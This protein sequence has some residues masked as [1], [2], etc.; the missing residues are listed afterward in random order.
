MNFLDRFRSKP[1]EPPAVQ[2]SV[3]LTKGDEAAT[4]ADKIPAALAGPATAA[5]YSLMKRGLF[6]MR[7]NVVVLLDHSGSMRQ[8]FQDGSITQLTSRVLAFALQIDTDGTVPVICFDSRIWPSVDVTPANF[9]T[10][11][12]STLWRPAQMGTTDL[13]GALEKILPM[14]KAA[15]EPII[16]VIITDGNPNNRDAATRLVC[17]LA[18]YPVWIK[19]L[20]LE[21]VEYLQALDDLGPDV[22]IVD[23]VDAQTSTP[24]RNLL[25]CSDEVFAEAMVEE[26]E[27]WVAAA[28]AKGILS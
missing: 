9:A 22:R 4:P 28:T 19:I 8:D 14:A 10:I 13:A 7:G 27:T 3:K 20:A 21:E 6:G 18:G 1:A 5:G 26:F 2:H 15:T 17:E 24:K 23:N 16:L 11:T 25:T 12:T